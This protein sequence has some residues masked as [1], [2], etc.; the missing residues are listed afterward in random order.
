MANPTIGHINCVFGGGKS[1]VRKDKKGKLYYY[2]ENMGMIKPNLIDGQAYMKK[3]TDFI[4]ENGTPLPPVSSV[5]E[6]QPVK[7]VENESQPVKKKS[8]LNYLYSN[9]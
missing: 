6:K 2:N 3:N 7:E 4:G 8:L 1:E 5:N 9:D